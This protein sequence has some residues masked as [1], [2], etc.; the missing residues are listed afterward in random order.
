MKNKPT[1]LIQDA[2]GRYKLKISL[3]GGRY[4]LSLDDRAV[5]LLKDRLGLSVR[6]TLSDHFVPFI[7]AM[8]DGWFPRQRDVDQ[9]IRDFSVE[10]SLTGNE[11]AA[12]TAYVTESYLT[13][14]NEERVRRV[15]E[16]SPLS[17]S[18][19]ASDLQIKELPSV[20]ESLFVSDSDESEQTGVVTSSSKSE[21][22]EETEADPTT[23]MAASDSTVE[24]DP[25]PETVES[26]QQIPGIGPLR[27]KQLVVGGVKSIETL[28][29]SRPNELATIDQISESIATV[30]IEGAR[31]LLGQTPPVDQRLEAQ[32][33]VEKEEF[34]S[35]LSSLAA[36]GVPASEAAPSLRV[37][38]GP[39]VADIDVV[40]GQQAY[41]L[42]EAGYQ[43]PHDIVTASQEELTDVMQVGTTTA[44]R[45]HSDAVDLLGRY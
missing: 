31:E 12:L 19:S 36:S 40:T 35:A 16:D 7:L 3:P 2:T 32:T 9:V 27:A 25:D 41:F 44:E 14:R 24:D 33:G 34:A 43:T 39:T 8:G 23:E 21:P 26:L 10:G 15:L 38:Y 18:V 45:I 1:R 29:D 11:R 42:W 37:L 30:A 13:E 5:N 28:A 4:Q 20:P 6:S 22:S 17:E